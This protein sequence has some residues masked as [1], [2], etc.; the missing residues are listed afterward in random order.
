[1]FSEPPSSGRSY[2]FRIIDVFAERAF[3][4]KPTAVFTDARG[5]GVA[6]MRA[7]ATE[8]R[9]PQTAFVFP[10]EGVG[11]QAKVRVFTPSAELPKAEHLTIAAVYALDVEEKLQRDQR[12]VLEEQEGP[13]SVYFRAKIITVR[14]Q[15][16]ALRSEHPEPDTV[17]AILGLR[18][19]D[20]HPC[21]PRAVSCSG[22]QFLV[23]AVKDALRL[24]QLR[25]R[26]DIWERTVKHFE[27]PNIAIFALKAGTQWVAKARVFLPAFGVPEDPATESACGPMIAYALANRLIKPP[28]QVVIGVEQ[29]AEIGRPSVIQVFIEHEA[30]QIKQVRVGGQCQLVGEGRV[31]APLVP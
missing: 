7:L 19:N 22:G 28:E 3:A 23:V 11:A 18:A 29:G 26:A 9:F 4:G 27:A 2:T 16:P 15:V 17:A 21:A 10:S 31:L 12:I 1:M 20:F 13:V 6:Q 14:Q 24:E 5:L 8:L 25:F 30:G